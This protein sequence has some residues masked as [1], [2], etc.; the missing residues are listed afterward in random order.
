MINEN[1]VHMEREH[2]LVI[3]KA[4]ELVLSLKGKDSVHR[5]KEKHEKI[6]YP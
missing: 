3:G 2:A 5:E 4:R 1:L 6:L